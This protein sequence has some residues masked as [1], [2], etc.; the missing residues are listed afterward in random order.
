MV[1]DIKYVNYFRKRTYIYVWSGRIRSGFQQLT[2]NAVDFVFHN[3]LD[4]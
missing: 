3:I 1:L 2:I 4:T